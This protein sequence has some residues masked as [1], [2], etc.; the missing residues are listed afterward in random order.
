LRADQTALGWIKIVIPDVPHVNL[1]EKRIRFAHTSKN[2]YR[3]KPQQ[4]PSDNAPP[5]HN[6]EN[7]HRCQNGEDQ[8]HLSITTK[9]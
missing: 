2:R 5:L 9:Q 7:Q 4:N 3:A 8:H 1:A 6:G